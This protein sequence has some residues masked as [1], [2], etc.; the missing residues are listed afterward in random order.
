MSVKVKCVVC[1]YSQEFDDHTSMK[2]LPVLCS[3]CGCELVIVGIAH[4]MRDMHPD[5]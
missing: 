4:W 3:E 5:L 1:D 2:V